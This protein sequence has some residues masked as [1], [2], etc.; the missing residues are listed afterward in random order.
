MVFFVL[1]LALLASACSRSDATELR[2]W[3]REAAA[4]YLD[5]RAEWWLQWP[6]A[7]RDHGTV[8]VSCH[9]TLPYALARPRLDSA[10]ADRVPSARQRVLDDVRTRVRRWDAVDP[11]YANRAGDRSKTTE[12]RATEAVLNALMLADDDATDGVALDDVARAFDHMWA[13]QQTEGD[14]RGAWP[15]LQF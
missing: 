6:Q 2:S 14:A 9:T 8:C 1:F 10:R 7:A 5:R 13:L 12:S 11:Y 3:N 4:A 15:W